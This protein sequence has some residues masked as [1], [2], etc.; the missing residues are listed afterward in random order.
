MSTARTEPRVS[1]EL[2]AK[3]RDSAGLT[4]YKVADECGMAFS[5]L[6]GW[7]NNDNSIGIKTL[8][9][10]SGFFGVPI[11]TFIEKEDEHTHM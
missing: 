4:D 6:Y 11:E 3:L 5:V 2:Y 7:K 8:L 9:K 1:Y 10:L